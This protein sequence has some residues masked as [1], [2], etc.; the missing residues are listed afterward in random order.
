MEQNIYGIEKSP[1]DYYGA[2]QYRFYSLYNGTR[3]AWHYS[4][5]EAIKNGET[6]QK[7]ILLLHAGNQ[8]QSDPYTRMQKMFEEG[9]ASLNGVIKT[10]QKLK[11][12]DDA[13][14]KV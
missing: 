11:E 4:K 14:N 8:V 9:I 6:H 13:E 10:L 7:T 1:S 5:E 2:C 3:G 12:G